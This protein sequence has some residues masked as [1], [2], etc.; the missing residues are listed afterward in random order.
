MMK[1]FW[2]ISGDSYNNSVN[3]FNATE[4][5]TNSHLQ[6]VKKISIMLHIFH[7]KKNSYKKIKISQSCTACKQEELDHKPRLSDSRASFKYGGS[8]VPLLDIS[9]DLP[10]SRNTENG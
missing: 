2:V 10:I 5:L 7:F 4:L 8:V 3:V 1:K 9:E 6:M